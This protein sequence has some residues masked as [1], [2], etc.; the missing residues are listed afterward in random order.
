MR[1][2]Q[3]KVMLL[4]LSLA[5]LAGC[6]GLS[7]Q[8]ISKKFQRPS[9]CEE[10]LVALDA[11]VID[12]GVLDASSFRIPGFPYLRTNR[13]L[14]SL[15]GTWKSEEG[16]KQWVELMRGLDLESRAKEIS[17][18]PDE[19]VLPIH[20]REEVLS[21][22]E[23]LLEQVR[24]CSDTLVSHDMSRSD[25][26]GTLKPLVD[27]PNEYS[28][29]LMSVGLYPVA[30]LPVIAVT[31]I[32]R[33]K[34]RSWYETSLE[35]LPLDGRLKWFAPAATVFLDEKEVHG[36]MD[37]SKKNPLNI[38]LP[39]G[40]IRGRLVRSFAPIFIQ[41]V[42]SS[43]DEPGRV[44]WNGGRA[45]VDTTRPAVYYYFSQAFLKG[46]PI[47]QINYVIWFSERTGERPPRIEKGH[48]DG[49]TVRVSL[50]P[51]DRPFMVDVINNCG[52]YHLFVPD[53]ERVDRVVPQPS[54]FDPFVPQW[55]PAI[56]S[57][58]RL[59]IRLSSGWHQVQ[60][61]LAVQE[62]S[63]STPYE[64][65]PYDVIESLS[66]ED[67][68]RESL[69]D[70]Q[71]IAKGSERMERYVLFSMGIP[72]IGSMRQRGHHAIELIGRAHFDDPYL[73]ERNFVFK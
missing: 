19:M 9:G 37:A 57:G 66:R 5:F 25:F 43:Y 20:S 53:R 46:E 73:F 36:M 54:G 41:D 18:L 33:R 34:I 31:D 35:N 14:S 61:L 42:A 63:D 44:I 26:F 30:A 55:L 28:L 12:A 59:G 39:E 64:L 68:R 24:V 22:R 10:F 56:P 3:F 71:G 21:S 16:K 32:S 27:V 11:K 67:G 65:I 50:D 8:T 62:G 49:L 6:A 60:R 13:F 52:C 29:F 4:I 69:F 58:S 51:Q 2:G 15:K 17:N 38:P 72:S 40:D 47:L 48:L 1:I 70:M 23:R 7:P 45:E